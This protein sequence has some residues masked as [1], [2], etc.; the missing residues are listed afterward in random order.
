[1]AGK[2]QAEWNEEYKKPE[3][4]P[5][6]ISSGLASLVDSAT[7]GYLP[8]IAATVTGGDEEQMTKQFEAYQQA[9]PV[10]DAV[11]GVLGYAVP[12]MGAVKGLK[13]AGT[14]LRAGANMLAGRTPAWLSTR[15]G[16]PVAAAPTT[17]QT[18]RNVGRT[19]LKYGA[20]IATGA[21]VA[22]VASGRTDYGKAEQ[23]PPAEPPKEYTFPPSW[24]EQ[25][26]D[27]LGVTPTDIEGMVKQR[28]GIPLYAAEK[29]SGMRGRAPSYKD[30]AF[31]SLLTGYNTQYSAAET[32]ED[33]ARVQQNFM[34]MM[35]L[36]A[37]ADPSLGQ[38]LID[39]MAQDE[40]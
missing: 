18:V 7:L 10:A 37:G 2:T 5:W 29:L 13:L 24:E 39:K 12:G 22:S 23:P 38:V 32:P 25:W 31:D 20:P 35:A 17:M 34:K 21:T 16:L 27:K 14:G 33:Q 30:V 6:Q 28:G 8:K 4:A 11:G 26:A 19:G 40:E 1:M 15:L 9:N 3:Q 36:I